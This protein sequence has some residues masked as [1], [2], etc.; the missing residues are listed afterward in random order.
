MNR[1]A[2][3]SR[4]NGSLIS[5]VILEISEMARSAMKEENKEN[6]QKRRSRAAVIFKDIFLLEK[7]FKKE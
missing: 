1:K 6:V 3:G 7:R 4:N 5:K 2:M